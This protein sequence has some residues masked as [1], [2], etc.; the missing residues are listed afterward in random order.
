MSQHTAGTHHQKI[1]IS[2]SCSTGLFTFTA[3]HVLSI[4]VQFHSQVVFISQEKESSTYLNNVTHSGKTGETCMHAK[5]LQ[6]FENKF[7]F[8]Q[9]F[10]SSFR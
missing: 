5:C 3:V 4:D 6:K 7:S 9:Y 8:W 2:S 10:S 1:Q